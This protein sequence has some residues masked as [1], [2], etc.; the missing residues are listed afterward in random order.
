M[1]ATK[2]KESTSSEASSKP[3]H[4][5]S[6]PVNEIK[7]IDQ[8]LEKQFTESLTSKINRTNHIGLGFGDSGSTFSSRPQTNTHV[9]FEENDEKES[10]KKAEATSTSS[11]PPAPNDPKLKFK[12][13]S[14]VKSNS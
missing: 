7:K 12:K 13:M 10:P 3:M 14:F 1:G 5:H 4:Q 8:D 6:R 2:Q 9:K 11:A